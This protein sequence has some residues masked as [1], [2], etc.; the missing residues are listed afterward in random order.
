M[1]PL[2]LSPSLTPRSSFPLTHHRIRNPLIGIP[3][4]QLLSDV[5]TFANKHNLTDILPTLIKGALVAQSP[6]HA[7]KITELDD[8]DRRVLNEE[9]THR[10]KHPKQLYMTIILNSV[11]AAIQGVSNLFSN[12]PY[13]LSSS[14]K[15]LTAT[16]SGIKQVNSGEHTSSRK[17]LTDDNR[18]QWRKS[19][20]WRC[21]RY[22]RY[23]TYM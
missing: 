23:R 9:V 20:L 8:E 7:D 16:Y 19:Y 11:A 15:I 1:S 4:H 21:S 5:E 22:S 6:H 10:W 18:C 17:M 14:G 3:K 2:Y 13:G 12:A